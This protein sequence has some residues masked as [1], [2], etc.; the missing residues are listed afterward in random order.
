MRNQK[1]VSWVGM[2]VAEFDVKAEAPPALH[3]PPPIV[4]CNLAL[5]SVKARFIFV[6]H[7]HRFSSET[8]VHIFIYIELVRI[9]VGICTYIQRAIADNLHVLCK[10]VQYGHSGVYKLYGYVD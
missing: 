6:R 10:D 9:N 7:H 8:Y 3:P 1:F 4:P 5:S 2:A